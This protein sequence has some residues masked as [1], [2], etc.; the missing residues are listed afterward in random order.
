MR[1]Q[2]PLFC[3]LQKP[4]GRFPLC[5]RRHG[6]F[7]GLVFRVAIFVSL[8]PETTLFGF[9]TLRALALFFRS[10]SLNLPSV[11]PRF[12]QAVRRGLLHLPQPLPGS[13]P[14]SLVRVL[15]AVTTPQRGTGDT[16]LLP[17]SFRFNPKVSPFTCLPQGQR[18]PVWRHLSPEFCSGPRQIHFRD[19]P[20]CCCDE[21][22]LRFP[23]PLARLVAAL[24]RSCSL[25][26]H[27]TTKGNG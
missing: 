7:S 22:K 27:D 3:S 24:P 23:P 16:C 25:C 13:L 10:P 11:L 18:P 2:V 14:R 21:L 6:R 19:Y 8:C 5:Q 15:F 1:D 26:G 20:R 17:S 9:R 4:F 12:Q